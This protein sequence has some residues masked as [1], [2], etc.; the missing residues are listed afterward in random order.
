MDQSRIITLPP[1]SDV[2]NTG[3]LAE[4]EQSYQNWA[5][6]VRGEKSQAARRR[7]LAIFLLI[8]YTGAKLS[9]VLSL[10]GEDIDAACQ[11]IRFHSGESNGREV[12]ISEELAHRLREVLP[13]S[14]SEE[15]GAAAIKY[16]AVDPGF[17][18]RK[19]YERATACGFDKKRGGPEMIRRA[20]AVELMRGNLPLPAVQRLLGHS[21]PN[22]TTAYLSFSD[23]D[24]RE[25]TRLYME[26]ESARLTSAR[27]SFFGKVRA[28]R[29]GE[30][31]TLVELATPDGESIFAIITR[32]SAE[33]LGLRLGMLATAEVKAPWLILESCDRP[34]HSSADNQ[35]EGV[36]VRIEAGRVNTECAVRLADGAEL[37]AVLSTPGFLRL[38]LKEGDP[39]RI[40]FSANAVI[41][42]SA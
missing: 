11:S 18:R 14:G 24:M 38:G 17:I 25:A 36:I 8:R 9:E 31:Q 26:R 2:L 37:C 4:L 34:G 12:R 16:F 23:E 1:D 10:T 7:I 42:Q 13:S 22:L 20:R 27:N 33:R 28:L 5:A 19:F 6:Q 39:A 40:L 15:K 29:E 3:Q 21:S 35:R 30:V 41:L 32:A